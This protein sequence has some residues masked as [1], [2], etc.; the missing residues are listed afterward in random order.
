LIL[1]SEFGAKMHAAFERD[2]A[3]SDQITL[4]AWKRHSLVTRAKEMFA[5]LGEYWL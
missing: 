5:R 4:E 1:G 3:A 2:L